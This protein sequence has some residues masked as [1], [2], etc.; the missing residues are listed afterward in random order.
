MMALNGLPSSSE[1]WCMVWVC[2]LRCVV[3][4][5]ELD[6]ERFS[7]VGHLALRNGQRCQAGEKECMVDVDEEDNE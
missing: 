7:E 2:A 3:L 5:V 1:T 4:F 6:E